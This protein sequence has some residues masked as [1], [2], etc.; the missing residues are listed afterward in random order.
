LDATPKLRLT[1]YETY[2]IEKHTKT[3]NVLAMDN[4]K[5][6]T[7]SFTKCG[8]DTTAIANL[9]GEYDVKVLVTD[10][11]TREENEKK[12]KELL[13]KGK[14]SKRTRNKNRPCLDHFPQI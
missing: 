12:K 5:V 1:I 2:T 4:I 3:M 11:G 9:S 14:Q 6:H 7:S 10:H 8:H 13:K